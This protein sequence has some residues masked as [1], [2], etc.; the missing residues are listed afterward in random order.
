MNVVLYAA[1]WKLMS[2]VQTMGYCGNLILT[3]TV[4]SRF[5]CNTIFLL[6]SLGNNQKPL[7]IGQ[8][9]DIFAKWLEVASSSPAGCYLCV[10]ETWLH[11]WLRMRFLC[12]WKKQ[13]NSL[14]KKVTVQVVGK[15]PMQITAWPYQKWQWNSSGLKKKLAQ[16]KWNS[17]HRLE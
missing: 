9:I 2:C 12:T 11:L 6:I 8:V 4:P 10:T 15:R 3:K 7:K 13:Q 5:L 14:F 16:V 17:P 1:K